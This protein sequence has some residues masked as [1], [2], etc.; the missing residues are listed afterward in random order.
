MKTATIRQSELNTSEG[1]LS[2]ILQVGVTRIY[3]RNEISNL[4]IVVNIGGA[5]SSKSYSIAQLFVRR[6]MNSPSRKMLVTRKT[7]PALYLTSYSLIV[8]LLQEYGLYP[9]VFHN[10]TH[11]I[12]ENPRNGAMIVFVSIDDP[13]KIKSTDWNDVW[14]EEANEFDWNDFL[15]IQTRM[16]SPNLD[17]SPNQIFMSLNPGEEQGWINQRVLLSP[18]F[19]EKVDTIWSTYKDNPW[20]SKDYIDSLESLIDQDADAYRIF[21][22]GQFGKLTNIIYFPYVELKAFPEEFDEEIYGLD[23]GYNNPSA[24]IRIQTKDLME[25]YLTQLIY[26]THLTN[27]QLIDEAKEFI[28]EDRRW[29]PLYCDAAEPDRIAEFVSAGFNAIPADKEVKTGIDFCKRMRFF[30]LASNVDLNKESGI[31]KWRT[32]KNGNVLDEP[33]KWM[34]HL[35]DAKRYALYT[36]FKDQLGMPSLT[37]I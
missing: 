37:V 21:A 27:T 11:S 14:M 30:T 15:V 3:D 1:D 6:L 13:E 23:F 19:K 16:R 28:P 8:R 5:G 24:L 9:K 33:V 31:Y 29:C 25:Q 20:L 2:P 34:D 35:M 12:I 26:K 22:L 10:K 7:G 36:H 17:G 4:P 18:A 32:D